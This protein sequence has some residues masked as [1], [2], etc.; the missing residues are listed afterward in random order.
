MSLK[1]SVSFILVK[2]QT[3]LEFGK[4]FVSVC[5]LN[6][7]YLLWR[8]FL[9]TSY[10]ELKLLNPGLPIYIRC[11]DG[12][13]PHISTRMGNGVYETSSVA[14][15][16]IQGIER[17]LQR[18]VQKGEEQAKKP[19]SGSKACQTVRFADII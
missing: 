15:L 17:T 1:K 18:M 19:L 13:K 6:V 5:L 10:G 12:I 4:Y 2:T 8:N 16:D 14:G 11:C 7:F 3:V 9:A